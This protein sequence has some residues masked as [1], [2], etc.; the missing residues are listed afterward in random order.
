MVVD[1]DVFAL[2]NC[3]E[4]NYGIDPGRVIALLNVGPRS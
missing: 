4:I 1:V 3:Y 2:Q